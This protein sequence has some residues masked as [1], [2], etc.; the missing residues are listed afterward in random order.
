VRVHLFAEL[1][2]QHSGHTNLH[3]K[4]FSMIIHFFKKTG[5]IVCTQC[6]EA[7]HLL[8][9]AFPDLE[10]HTYKQDGNDAGVLGT[11]AWFEL[12]DLVE[13]A[14]YPG[15][16]IEHQTVGVVRLAGMPAVNYLK[17]MADGR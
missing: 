11:M 7:E 10:V 15:L 9:K 8:P 3:T 16:Y 13:K 5:K 12:V 6:E 4:K 1:G 14:G 17:E 2:H